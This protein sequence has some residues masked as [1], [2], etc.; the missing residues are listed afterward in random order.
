MDDGFMDGRNALDDLQSLEVL[1]Q[2]GRQDLDF[3]ATVFAHVSLLRLVQIC[4]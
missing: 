1:E 2:T 4:R 3:T